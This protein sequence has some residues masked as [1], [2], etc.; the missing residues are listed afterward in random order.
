MSKR[1]EIN[2]LWDKETF[3]EASKATYDFE[4]NH[5]PKRFFGWFFIAM[6]QFG[7]VGALKKDAYAL[8]IIATVLVIYWYSLRWPI[9]KY[10]IAKT[11]D[12]QE[13]KNHNFRMSAGVDGIDID[14]ADISWSEI[15]E[16]VSLKSGFLL[17]YGETFLYIPKSAFVNSDE[18]DLFSHLCKAN[19]TQ[20]RKES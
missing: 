8:L 14:D 19:V 16:V 4:L 10:I 1:I 6:T 12:A 17:F 11:F 9:R 18:K 5:S 20:Y 2:Y 15:K 13:H 3:L 7:V